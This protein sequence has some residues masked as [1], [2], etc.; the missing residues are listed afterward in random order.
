ME[1]VK[2]QLEMRKEVLGWMVYGVTRCIEMAQDEIS[3][4]DAMLHKIV[5]M[6]KGDSFK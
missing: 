6:K 2:G 5:R 4:V 1:S 3:T